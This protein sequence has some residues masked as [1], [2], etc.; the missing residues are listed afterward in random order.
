[1]KVAVIGSRGLI[2]NN[3]E[4]YLPKA[5]TEIISG[6]AVGVDTSAEE[7]A[8]S[9]NLK[10]TEFLPDY[11]KYGKAAPLK[12]NITIIKNADLVLAFWD[13]KS[14]GTNFVIDN[15]NRHN[16]PIVVYLYNVRAS[17][18]EAVTKN[19]KQTQKNDLN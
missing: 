19:C 18:F 9:N 10:L 2:V 12:R 8:L 3:L 13:E 6:G 17:A 15:C 5:V 16:I 11:K 7:F 4:Q 14:R 1:M